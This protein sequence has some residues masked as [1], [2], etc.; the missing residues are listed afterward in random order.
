MKKYAFKLETL[1]KVRN[2]REEEAEREFREALIAFQ[3]ALEELD[4]YRKQLEEAL[5][6]CAMQQR[7]GFDIRIQQLYV[8]YFKRLKQEISDQTEVVNTAETEM[9]KRREMLLE[10]MKDRKVVDKLRARDYEAYSEELKRWEQKIIDDLAVLRHNSEM[11]TSRVI[12]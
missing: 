12:S 11:V 9:E 3:Q 2:L 8:T 10:A 7:D 1:L 6:D 5:Q 4:G